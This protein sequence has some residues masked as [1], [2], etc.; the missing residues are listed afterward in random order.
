MGGLCFAAAGR[1]SFDSIPLHFESVSQDVS[2]AGCFLGRAAGYAVR[3][4][5]Q[6]AEIAVA[7]GGLRLEWLKPN[8]GALL[9]PEDILPGRSHYFFGSD[10]AQWRTDVLQYGRVLQLK[11]VRLP[12]HQAL[13][14]VLWH[15][16]FPLDTVK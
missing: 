8:S 3:V 15:W 1:V 14:L 4:D 10:P 13:H 2:P 11:Q 12:Y 16:L 6:G 5:A 9:T 7:E